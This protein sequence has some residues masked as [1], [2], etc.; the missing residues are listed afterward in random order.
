MFSVASD[1]CGS[2]VIHAAGIP[3]PVPNGDWLGDAGG[4]ADVLDSDSLSSLGISEMNRIPFFQTS[5]G[6]ARRFSCAEY[7]PTPESKTGWYL[8]YL[9]EGGLGA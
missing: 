7:H 5:S 9:K 1:V 4:P 6:G 3:K 8:L 2:H